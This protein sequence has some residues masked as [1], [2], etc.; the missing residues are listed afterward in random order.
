[1]SCQERCDMMKD[2]PNVVKHGKLQRLNTQYFSISA[3]TV[4]KLLQEQFK[5]FLNFYSF[6]NL[7]FSED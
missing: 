7:A 2:K 5:F 3:N 4:I 1:M 6:Q